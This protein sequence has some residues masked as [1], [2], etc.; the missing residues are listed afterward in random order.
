MKKESPVP[1]PLPRVVTW[2]A[3]GQAD[4]DKTISLGSACRGKDKQVSISKAIGSEPQGVRQPHDTESILAPADAI[5][6]VEMREPHSAKKKPDSLEP[7]SQKIDL[8]RH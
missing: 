6:L 2:R 3:F 1:G 7:G 5:N 4:F 8:R